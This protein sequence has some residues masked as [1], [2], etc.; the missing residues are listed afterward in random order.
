MSWNIVAPFLEDDDTSLADDGSTLAERYD[1]TSLA[2]KA[3][4]S[5]L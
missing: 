5:S 1:M 3:S 2:S 4:L